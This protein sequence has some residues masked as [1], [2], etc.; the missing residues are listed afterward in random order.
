MGV[1]AGG[2]SCGLANGNLVSFM[3]FVL[4]CTDGTAAFVNVL[5]NIY[6]RVFCI[7]GIWEQLLDIYCL[8]S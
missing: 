1:L 2:C 7:G 4:P 6:I 5:R 8:C 3:A